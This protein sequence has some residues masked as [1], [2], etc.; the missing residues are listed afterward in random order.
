MKL[1]QDKIDAVK[2]AIKY[3]ELY[4]VD[5]NDELDAVNLQ[6]IIDTGYPKDDMYEYWET[7]AHSIALEAMREC[8]LEDSE[9]SD[10]ILEQVTEIVYECCSND[11]IPQLIQNAGAQPVR[12]TAYSN[13]EGVRSGYSNSKSGYEYSEGLKQV[14]DILNINPAML[15][16]EL[17]S[18]GE[19]CI[20]LYPNKKARDSKEYVSVASLV[21]ELQNTTS[22]CNLLTFV[23]LVDAWDFYGKEVCTKVTFPKGNSAWLIDTMSGGGSLIECTLLRDFTVDTSKLHD[24]STCDTWALS[25]DSQ[26]GWY[27]ID[28]IYWVSGE[29]WGKEISAK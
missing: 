8:E 20:W 22:E 14:V 16:K 11:P 19:K 13:Y 9:N 15:K 23:G 21:S 3:N 10:D 18:K 2:N 1:S 17:I 24:L 6:C 28:S 7:D 29:F 25:I 5:Y 4:Y 27:S 26:G 12:L